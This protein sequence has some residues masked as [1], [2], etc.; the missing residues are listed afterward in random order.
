MNNE[1]VHN[2]FHK[3]STESSITYDITMNNVNSILTITGLNCFHIQIRL[4]HSEGFPSE[5]PKI[6]Y[7]N[8]KPWIS[9][10]FIESKCKLQ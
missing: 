8:C 2:V 7:K 3:G 10:V 1:K 5:S 4:I 9:E 6:Y